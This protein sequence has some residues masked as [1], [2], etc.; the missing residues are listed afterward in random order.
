[1]V[2]WWERQEYAEKL[3]KLREESERLKQERPKEKRKALKGGLERPIEHRES[4]GNKPVDLTDATFAEAVQNHHLAVVDCWAPWC[5]PCSYV[6]PI[7]EEMA[8]DYA[9][10]IL[11][12][13]LNVDNNRKV[14][15]KYGVMSIPTLLMFKSGKL[16]DQ[17]IG[18][19]PREKL[20]PMITQY[21][22]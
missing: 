9:G 22:E 14:A 10:K 6:S 7:I 11:F 20:E 15:M 13:K 5:H 17:I 4:A 21:L 8:G 16:V 19:M 12:G 3:K 18:A 1:M 2:S